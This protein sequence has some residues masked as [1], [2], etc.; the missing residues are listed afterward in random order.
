[1]PSVRWAPLAQAFGDTSIS[2]A[3][4]FAISAARVSSMVARPA[5]SSLLAVALGDGFS[6]TGNSTGIGGGGGGGY[7]ENDGYHGRRRGGS[8]ALLSAAIGVSQT[9]GV[10]A[11][12]IVFA[13]VVGA[14]SGNSGVNPGVVCFRLAAVAFAGVYLA[15]SLVHATG[16][17]G[18]GGATRV[19]AE[20]WRG[21]GG[22]GGSSGAWLVSCD[23]VEETIEGRR[24]ASSARGVGGGVVDVWASGS[25]AKES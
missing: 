6:V 25:A 8:R 3:V 7:H 21:G 13:R 24:A 10:L 18:A 9:V 22:V 11:A 2:A 5:L 16:G 4:F 14:A 20:G 17:V 19:G 23:V 15:T 12:G 1:M